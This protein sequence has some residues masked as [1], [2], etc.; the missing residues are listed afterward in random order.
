M[1][2]PPFERLIF[3]YFYPIRKYSKY[4]LHL[5]FVRKCNDT[6]YTTV[7]FLFQNF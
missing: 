6:P 1:L 3:L 7:K 2:L 5:T 4:A